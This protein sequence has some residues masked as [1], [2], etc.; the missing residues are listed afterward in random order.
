[1]RSTA[2]LPSRLYRVNATTIVGS[3]TASERLPATLIPSPNSSTIVGISS[4]PPATPMTA[5]TTPIPNPAATPASTT[6]HQVSGSRSTLPKRLPIRAPAIATS[7]AASTRYSVAERIFVA[8]DAPSHAPARLPANRFTTAVHCEAT[9]DHGT[10]ASR[11]GS[12][13]N[14]LLTMTAGNAVNP[15]KAISSGSRNSAP[16]R[17]IMPPSTPTAAQAGNASGSDG[18]R[19]LSLVRGRSTSWWRVEDSNLGSFRDG[20]TVHGDFDLPHGR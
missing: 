11:A 19:P 1:V 7:S 2:K 13:V 3:E 9:A 18:P 16:P 6:A 12:T 17:P 20:F 8:H 15:N 14:T 10:D 5:A 4:S